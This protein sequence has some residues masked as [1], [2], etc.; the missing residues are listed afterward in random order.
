MTRLAIAT[1][2]CLMAT[3]AAALQCPAYMSRVDA[4]LD[5]D[6]ALPDA[7]RDRVRTLRDEGARLYAAGD[8][9]GCI[10]RLREALQILGIE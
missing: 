7:A 8:R 2:F 9:T 10:S 1:V 6:T 5:A 4:A 3:P